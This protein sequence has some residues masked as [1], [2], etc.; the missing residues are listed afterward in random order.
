[1]RKGLI[2]LLVATLVTGCAGLRM[3][4]GTLFAPE[5]N[6][7]RRLALQGTQ[8]LLCDKGSVV[9]EPLVGMLVLRLFAIALGDVALGKSCD[10]AEEFRAPCEAEDDPICVAM[11][12]LEREDLFRME[13]Q[14]FVPPSNTQNVFGARQSSTQVH[15]VKSF[16]GKELRR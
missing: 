8:Y 13:T 4:L 6:D 7:A 14:S 10:D 12:R 9:Q 1:M 5:L 3:G 11:S 16:N 15:L 2:V